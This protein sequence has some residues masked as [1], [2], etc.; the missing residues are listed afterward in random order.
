MIASIHIQDDADKK[1]L[2]TNA[3]DF[4]KQALILNKDL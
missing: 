3:V 4:V 2:E 1:I